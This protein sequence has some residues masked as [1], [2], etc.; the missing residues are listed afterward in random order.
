MKNVQ[1]HIGPKM[2][3]TERIAEGN[4]VETSEEV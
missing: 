4:M 1:Q 3:H 2:N